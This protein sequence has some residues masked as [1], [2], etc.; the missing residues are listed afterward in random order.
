M[1]PPSPQ[2]GSLQ[3]AES[4]SGNSEYAEAWA[5]GF[6]S[7]RFPPALEV[8]YRQ[9]K[10]ADRLRLIR[11]GAMFIMVMTGILLVTDWIMVP[12]QF[13]MAVVLR[14]LIETPLVLGILLS[15]HR[16]APE[17]RERLTV[18]MNLTTAAVCTY[19]VVRSHDELAPMYLVALVVLPMFTGSA[20][21]LPFWRAVFVDL[22]VLVMFTFGAFMV[23]NPPIPVML[24]E[25]LVMVS[26][27]IFTLFCVHRSEYEERANWLMQQQQQLLRDEVEHTN[28]QLE[29]LSR[30]D[31]LT[32]LANRRYFDEFLQSAWSRAQR[33]RSNV[34]LLM[35]DIDHFKAYNDHYGH[36]Q[37]DIC[38]QMVAKAMTDCLRKPEGLVARY[39]GEEFAV[40][41]PAASLAI[42]QAAAERIRQG[43]ARQHIVH[44]GSP[45]SGELTLSIGVACMQAGGADASAASLIACAD[46]ALYQAKT[47]GRNAVVALDGPGPVPSAPAHIVSLDSVEPVGHTDSVRE[48]IDT[49]LTGI[50]KPWSTL[51]FPSKLET[52]FLSD[53]AAERARYFAVCGL[54]AFVVFNC[55]LLT[56]YLL[57]SDVMDFAIKVRLGLFTPAAT[58]LLCALWFNREWVLRRWPPM[59]VETLVMLSGVGAAASL[60]VILSASHLPTSQVYPV[61]LMVV[62]VYGNLVQRLRFWYAVVFTLIV[63]AIHVMAVWAL[64]TFNPRLVIPLG[65]LI[66]SASIFSLM[67]NYSLERDQRKR[68]LLKLVQEQ[69]L[70]EL[71]NVRLRL[72]RLSRMDALTGLYNRRH[73]QEYLQNVWQR[74]QHDGSD[75]AIIMLD[76]DHFKKFN[77]RYG[78]QAGDACLSKVA[79]A[80][81]SCLREPGDLVARFGG[82]EFIA[83][84]PQANGAMAY[85]AAERV[86]MAVQALQ[87]THADSSAAPVVTVSLGVASMAVQPGQI[88]AALIKSADDALY[89]AKRG[90]R[91][92][93]A[94][95]H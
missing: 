2:A 90:G 40:V 3:F 10:E 15:L 43:V 46:A 21:R 35:I 60:G 9:D 76:V 49:A 63:L 93:V 57:V 89:E 94:P 91:N 29:K 20:V 48:R 69:V 65:A 34:A 92:R 42:A 32:D 8:R 27:T 55:F 16:M 25:A 88:D 86:R 80:M 28:G 79:E 37:G 36:A 7:L 19:I 54:V 64:P 77:D 5:Q 74:A 41:L 83:V 33:Q 75:V 61:G 66:G 26:T 38:I 59:V 24:S 4:V 62:I 18:L 70:Q 50:D 53:I 56:D 73:F 39:G 81:R 44:V 17:V 68:Y 13:R 78:H 1:T 12:D 52:Q 82:E 22:M 58:A 87:L 14:V 45:G 11:I 67:A 6:K 47:Q 30:F 31:P 85:A 23:D 84:L 72:Q 95:G 51:A 71:G